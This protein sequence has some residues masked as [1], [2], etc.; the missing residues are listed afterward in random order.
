M[1]NVL[2]NQG[3]GWIAEETLGIAIFCALK[4]KKN[5]KKAIE[6]SVNHD[7]DS[8]STGNLVGQILGA[9]YGTD[10]LPVNYLSH[11]EL[12]TVIEKIAQQ[13]AEKQNKKY[14]RFFL[15]EES[16]F[17]CL[18]YIISAFYRR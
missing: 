16:I 9:K 14:S 6:V 5:F 4:Y 10:I 7:G 12:R 13:L 15:I 3:E 1:L 11:L 18:K 8:D 2:K 17:L